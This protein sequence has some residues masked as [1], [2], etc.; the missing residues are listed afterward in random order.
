MLAQGVSS[1]FF[2]VLVSIND[3]VVVDNVFV[4][5]LATR[6]T[7]FRKSICMIDGSMLM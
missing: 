4:F 3:V 5:L 6:E 7:D 2:R 1:A